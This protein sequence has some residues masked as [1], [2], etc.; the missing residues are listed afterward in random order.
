MD[1][2][3]C[4]SRRQWREDR[5]G[6]AV[7]TSSGEEVGAVR[8]VGEREKDNAAGS[9][10]AREDCR[11]REGHGAGVRE[12]SSSPTSQRR[13]TLGAA[14]RAGR[15]SRRTTWWA[16]WRPWA[17]TITPTR[18]LSTWTTKIPT[19]APCRPL[20]ALELTLAMAVVE[21]KALPLGLS[22][23]TTTSFSRKPYF[24]C[25][26][27]FDF[28]FDFDGLQLNSDYAVHGLLFDFMITMLLLSM[29][30]PVKRT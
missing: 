22:L 1:R 23:G 7:A 27:C 29:F 24:C 25:C 4:S 18:S 6:G 21:E 10:A 9:A 2:R 5:G 16:P 19:V 17:S 3:G 30:F 15:R 14:G 11:R 8:A 26:C 20:V 28:N 13:R 12:G